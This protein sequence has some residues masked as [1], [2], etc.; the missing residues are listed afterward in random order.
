[1]PDPASLAGLL[2]WG[3]EMPTK[4]YDYIVVGSGAIEME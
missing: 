3:H 4:T 1:M 2:N